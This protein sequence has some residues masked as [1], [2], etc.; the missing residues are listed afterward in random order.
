MDPFERWDDWEWE[1]AVHELGQKKGNGGPSWRDSGSGRKSRSVRKRDFLSFWSGGQKRTVLAAMFFLTVF[2]SANGQDIVSKGVYSI[3]HTSQSSDY[4]A[5]LTGMAKEALGLGGVSLTAMPV[6]SK[7]KGKFMPPVSGPVEA[8]FGITNAEG[9][10]HEGIDVGS[11]LG[12]KVVAPYT[13]V[14][15]EVG[16]DE[17]LGNVVK[18]DYGDGWS[19]VL[20]N[21]G[22]ILV[23][24][25]DKVEIGQQIGTVGLSAPLQKPWLHIEL[26]KDDKAIDPLPYFMPTAS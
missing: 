24:K 6:D 23:K 17:Q 20:G 8:A 22:D 11:S 26:R 9:R 25:G 7:M 18:I 19:G 3:Y 10:V 12:T 5:T 1:K 4:Y 14:V 2:F 21:L 16:K 13:G 15:T